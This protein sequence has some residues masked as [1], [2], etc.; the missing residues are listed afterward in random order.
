MAGRVRRLLHLQPAWHWTAGLAYRALH[1]TAAPLL[2]PFVAGGIAPCR[3]SVSLQPIDK[4]SLRENTPAGISFAFSS[5][6]D[7]PSRLEDGPVA[8]VRHH[9]VGR[10]QDGRRVPAGRVAWSHMPRRLLAQ[11]NV[12][13]KEPT[14]A[15]QHDPVC[16]PPV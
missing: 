14:Y 2:S 13:S 10:G 7:T 12:Q 11:V 3:I 5:S 16:A 6:V 1:T 15:T 9:W 8:P 4:K